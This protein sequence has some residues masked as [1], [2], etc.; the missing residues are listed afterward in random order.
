M[1]QISA[2][3]DQAVRAVCPIYGIGIGR[4]DDKA[5]WRIDFVEAATNPQRT[6]AAAVVAGFDV[7]AAQQQEAT[8]QQ[9]LNTDR[10]E[11]I[12]ARLDAAIT[13][14]IDSTPAQRVAWANSNFPSLTAPERMR[15]GMIMNMIAVSMRPQIR[16]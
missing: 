13:A 12:D 9:R 15:I 4:L 8:E 2:L 5:T 6:A 16:Q 14:L 11:L 3:I 1:T 10:Q 7:G